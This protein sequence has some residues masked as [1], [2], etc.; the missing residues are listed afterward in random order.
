MAF[1][2]SSVLGQGMVMRTKCFGFILIGFL[3]KDNSGQL[4][5]QLVSIRGYILLGWKNALGALATQTKYVVIGGQNKNIITNIIIRWCPFCGRVSIIMLQKVAAIVNKVAA[6][7]CFT[8]SQVRWLL[9]IFFL[10]IAATSAASLCK[11]YIW[12]Q[13]FCHLFYRHF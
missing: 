7:L 9:K 1:C 2:S 4:G 11:W 8:S 10:T 12:I 13:Y 6:D 5:R 3:F